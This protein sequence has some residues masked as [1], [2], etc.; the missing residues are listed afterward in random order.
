M[1]YF[2]Y[3]RSQIVVP[4]VTHQI[5]STLAEKFPLAVITNGNADPYACGLGDYFQFVLKAGPD[6]RAKPFS[7]M[8][9]LVPRRNLIL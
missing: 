4:D 6:G 5:L 7:D 8:Y 3:W 1:A 2:S 9:Y